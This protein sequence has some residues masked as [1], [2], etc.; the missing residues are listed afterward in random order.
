MPRGG[1]IDKD[2]FE[3]IKD[4]LRRRGYIL[5]GI[6][7]LPGGS[8]DKGLT[9]NQADVFRGVKTAEGQIAEKVV[10]KIDPAWR[11]PDRDVLTTGNYSREVGEHYG[12]LS[13]GQKRY[14]QDSEK[15]INI[16]MADNITI[17]VDGHTINLAVQVIDEWDGEEIANYL[18][19]HDNLSSDF[20]PTLLSEFSGLFQVVGDLI[21]S[22]M[23]YGDFLGAE[24]LRN[25][26][27][28][29]KGET[30]V[31]DLDLITDVD[32]APDFWRDKLRMSTLRGLI[33]AIANT[34]ET[35]QES[36]VEGKDAKSILNKAI[37]TLELEHSRVE[38]N[39]RYVVD[40]RKPFVD[41]TRELAEFMAGI[42]QQYEGSAS[43]AIAEA[44]QGLTFTE[45]DWEKGG[46]D[47]NPDNMDME[48][49]GQGASSPIMDIPFDI[50]N[51]QGFTFQI[52][53][54]EPIKDLSNLFGVPQEK[55]V[56]SLP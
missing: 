43:S 48:I 54:I 20:V 50:Q 16:Q 18:E 1:S 51:F 10:V 13:N 46:I 24:R 42:A 55:E 31:I 47:L 45:R 5:T 44:K 36:K 6:L 19:K 35:I 17:V 9:G 32:S 11:S 37:R 28:N 27:V 14:L 53:R 12:E 3:A 30:I 2:Y 39:F 56:S 40:D 25:V 33:K 38:S 8:V 49:R 52:I 21:N 7:N 23:S 29:D 41:K 26:L 15:F 34:L 4:V 22:G